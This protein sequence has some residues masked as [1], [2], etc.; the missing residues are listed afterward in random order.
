MTDTITTLRLGYGGL[1]EV[2]GNPVLVTSGSFENSVTPAYT[3]GYLMPNDTTSRSRILHS[4]GTVTHSGNVGFDLTDDGLSAVKGLMKRNERFTVKL[5]DGEYGKRMTDCAVNSLAL[6]GNPSG[7]MTASIAFSSVNPPTDVSASSMN[8]RDSFISSTI[9]YW[10]SGNSYVRDW[11][12]S[13]SQTVSPRFGNKNV[14]KMQDDGILASSPLYL[15]VGE[16]SCTLDFTTFCPLVTD[17]V[18][19]ATTS[20]KVVGRTSGTGY[21]I[22]GL[23]DLPAYKYSIVSHAVG[24]NNNNMLT[25]G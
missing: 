23:E 8:R 7:Y 13:F 12:I 19:I 24:Y 2:A 21:T 3:S 20:F 15:F 17:T 1:A 14:Y 9:P 5:C 11:N 16:I 4:D 25:I 6:S 22:G 18:Y 10:W